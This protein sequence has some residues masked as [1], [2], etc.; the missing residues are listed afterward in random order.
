MLIV[1]K[2]RDYYDSVAG[3]T[4]IDKTLVYQRQTENFKDYKLEVYDKGLRNYGAWYM[5]NNPKCINYSVFLIGFCGKTYVCLKIYPYEDTP[6]FI[7]GYDN[8]V[9]YLETRNSKYRM[10]NFYEDYNNMVNYNFMEIYRKHHVPV[11]IID[12]DGLTI[13]PN[14]KELSFQKMFDC[15]SAFQEISMFIGG[16]LG[17]SENNIINI[18]NE[19]R[20]KQ[21]GFDKFSFRK[22]KD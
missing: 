12:K 16:V 21:Y 1:S 14:L 3:T 5:R 7:Y 17:T 20:I 15:Y 22:E 9:N 8:I 13:N 11:F 2:Y 18:S 19:D 6:Y 4:G 10:K